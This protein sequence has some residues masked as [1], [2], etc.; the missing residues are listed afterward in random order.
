M[1][2]HQFTAALWRWRPDG[3]DPGSWFFVHLPHEVADAIDDPAPRKGFGSVRVEVTL[4]STT[5]RTSVFPSK[6]HGTFL[7]PVKQSVR[8]RE[9]LDEGSRCALRIR[10]V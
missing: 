6:E 3:A 10:A 7:L 2:E 1:T 8:E 5:W 4:G 9:R